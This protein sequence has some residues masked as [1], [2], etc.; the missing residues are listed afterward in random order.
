LLAAAGQLHLGDGRT[1]FHQQIGDLVYPLAIWQSQG[2]LEKIIIQHEAP[3]A[4]RLLSNVG[5]L[6]NALG[7]STREI[8]VDV[9]P[10]QVVSTGAAH[11]L[12]PIRDRE[13]VDRI[14]T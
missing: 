9:V 11:L 13:A 6:A 1:W 2:R 12:V 4:G 5:A 8:A 10:C 14:F 7:L 3:M